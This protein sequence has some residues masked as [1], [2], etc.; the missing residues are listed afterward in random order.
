MAIR[1]GE[2]PGCFK[3]SFYEVVRV[4]GG[5]GKEVEMVGVV[6]ELT[7]GGEVEIGLVGRPFLKKI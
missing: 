7:G 1:N 6:V 4:G 2:D 3:N 5:G